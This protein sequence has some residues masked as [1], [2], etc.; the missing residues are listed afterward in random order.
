MQ[1]EVTISERAVGKTREAGEELVDVG[2]GINVPEAAVFNEGVKD[3]T[4]FTY[5]FA[6]HKLHIPSNRVHWAP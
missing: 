1:R 5:G 2:E 3:R 4:P 6:P